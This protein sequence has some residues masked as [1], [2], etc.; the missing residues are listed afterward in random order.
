MQRLKAALTPYAIPYPKVRIGRPYDGGYVVFNHKLNDVTSTYSYGINDDV[1]FELKYTA[2][3]NSPIY[4]YDHTIHGLPDSH[5]QFRFKKEAGSCENIVNHVTENGDRS[6]RSLFLK[7]DIEGHEYKWLLSLNETQLNK[8]KQITIEFHKIN[9]DSPDVP[10]L[11]KIACFE[12]LNNTHYII[13]IHGNNYGKKTNN[14]PHV[15]EI[16]YIRKDLF[17]NTP[18]FNIQPLPIDNLDYPN[19]IKKEDYNLNFSPF[20]NV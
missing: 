17:E 15:V 1:S 7:M 8:F 11:N 9:E 4:M 16:T 14:I 3:S 18:V 10:H 6:S 2:Y 5:P 19:N 20:V 13:H 12:K